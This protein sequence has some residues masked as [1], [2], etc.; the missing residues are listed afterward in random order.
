ML[1]LLPSSLKPCD[2]CQAGSE[3]DEDEVDDH[4]FGLGPGG[5]PGQG[6][7]DWRARVGIEAGSGSGAADDQGDTHDEDVERAA[8]STSRPSARQ[9]QKSSRVAKE[10]IE[11][12]EASSGGQAE[13]SE[14]DDFDGEEYEI[15]ETK[16]RFTEYSM[17]SSVVPRSEG[18]ELVFPQT[19][20]FPEGFSFASMLKT[21]FMWGAL[22]D[23]ST[24]SRRPAAA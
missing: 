18:A 3:C 7:Q 8:V 17:S 15:E 5:M 14:R 23:R 13:G 1:P 22:V 21:A 4:A 2:L 19:V 10:E 16:S 24:D 20:S 9:A 12:E 11:G 6:I